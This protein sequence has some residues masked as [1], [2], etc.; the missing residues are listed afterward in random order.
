MF[1]EKEGWMSGGRPT[2]CAMVARARLSEKRRSEPWSL[3]KS[4]PDAGEETNDQMAAV[5]WR[6]RTTSKKW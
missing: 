3:R 5:I 4:L 1:A 6:V 2:L